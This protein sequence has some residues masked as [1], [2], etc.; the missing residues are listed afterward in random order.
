MAKKLLSGTPLSVTEIAEKCGYSSY[1]YFA[2]QF[3]KNTGMTPSDYRK[4]NTGE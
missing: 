1:V 4:N 2:K 3:R